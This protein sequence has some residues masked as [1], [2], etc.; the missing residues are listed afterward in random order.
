MAKKKNIFKLEKDE[1]EIF[2]GAV[3][4]CFTGRYDHATMGDAILTDKRFLFK[5][6]LTLTKD[7]KFVQIFVKDIDFVSK[8]GIPLLTRSLYISCSTNTGK[9]Y[10]LNVY[11]FKKWKKAFLEV[12]PP[13]KVN[14]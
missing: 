11:S 5:S 6:D 9:N 10:R 14:L 13:E 7:D 2:Q 8:T 12:L 4:F 1:K 3:N